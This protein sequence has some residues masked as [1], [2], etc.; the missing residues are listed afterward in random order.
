MFEKV[1]PSHPDKV[2]DRI[3]GAIVD[4]AYAKDSN[5]KVAVEVLIGHNKCHIINESSVKLSTTDINKLVKRISKEELDVDYVEVPQDPFLAANQEKEIKCGDNGIFKGVPV[6]DEEKYLS[7]IVRDLYAKYTSDSKFVYDKD[8]SELIVCQSNVNSID[9]MNYLNARY[10]D[11]N[12]VIINPLG[13]W[14][15]G[16]NVDTGATNRKLG[17]DMGRAITGGGINGKDLS[18]SDVSVNIVC[19]ILAQQNHD[20]ITAKCAIGDNEI[21][22]THQETKEVEV[23]KYSDVVQ[24]AREYIVGLGGFEKLAEWGLI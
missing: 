4:L 1:S 15:G 13:D 18:K 7:S 10:C 11:I 3:A 5:P 17:S 20:V 23:Y 12:K 8:R 19:H 2:A 24:K 9:L 16:V 6:N 14:T 21:V 22:F